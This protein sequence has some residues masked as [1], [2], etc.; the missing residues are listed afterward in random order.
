MSASLIRLVDDWPD[1]LPLLPNGP[2]LQPSRSSSR[3]AALV[4][5]RNSRRVSAKPLDARQ[6]ERRQR[7]FARFDLGLRGFV[8]A[9]VHLEGLAA[10]AHVELGGDRAHHRVVGGVAEPI[11]LDQGD[12]AHVLRGSWNLSDLARVLRIVERGRG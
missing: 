10:L 1:L 2:R 4:A 5:A 6:D 8:V 12:T 7:L 9:D 3:A 11:A